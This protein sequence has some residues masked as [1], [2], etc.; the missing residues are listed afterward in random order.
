[1]IDGM[2]RVAR[3]QRAVLFRLGI[4]VLVLTF[5]ALTA[6]AAATGHPAEAVFLGVLASVTVI[7]LLWAERFLSRWVRRR[8]AM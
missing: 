6:I 1:M 2:S 8:D 7:A 3:S 5:I 4:A